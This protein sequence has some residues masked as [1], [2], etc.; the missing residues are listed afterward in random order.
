MSPFH[1]WAFTSSEECRPPLNLAAL[2]RG[3]FAKLRVVPMTEDPG[4][5]LEL[6]PKPQTLSELTAEL[7]PLKIEVEDAWW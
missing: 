7:A 4:F 6:P 5:N 1:R 3:T 2:P